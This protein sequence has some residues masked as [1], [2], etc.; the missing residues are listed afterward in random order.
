MRKLLAIV[1]TAA[2]VVGLGVGASH[3]AQPGDQELA[4]AGV[5]T[6]DDFPA[7]WRATPPKKNKTDP[8]KCP[9]VEKVV[10][11]LRKAKKTKASSDDYEQGND[12]YSSSAVVY[13]TEDVTR[14]IY[15]AAA[16]RD[17][18]GCVSKLVKD[19]VGKQDQLKG[20]DVKVE[21]G[22]VT[23]GS[24]G[25]ESANIGL[26]LTVSKGSLSQDEFVDIVFVRVGRSLGFYSHVSDKETST[27]NEF[28]PD[29]CVSF[30]GL[31]TS[32]T[33]RLAGNSAPVT[34]T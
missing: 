18:R 22:T 6:A 8:L 29:D 20:F 3:A 26:K 1:A 2:A 14:R 33:G 34:T 30:T 10:S 12:Q 13:G 23:G 25:D 28:S 32:A 4:K 24:Y 7:G 19:E 15:K 9:A 31:I 5:F 16:S 27:C 11:G 17:F 21:V